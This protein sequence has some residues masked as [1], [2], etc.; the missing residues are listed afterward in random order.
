MKYQ[1]KKVLNKTIILLAVICSVASCAVEKKK[2]KEQEIAQQTQIEYQKFRAEW[3]AIGD[4]RHQYEA[5]VA[6]TPRQK[7]D[8]RIA[9]MEEVLSLDWTEQ[10]RQHIQS[11]IE[12]LKDEI[13]FLLIPPSPLPQKVVEWLNYAVEEFGWSRRCLDILLPVSFGQ[14]SLFQVMTEV[15]QKFLKQPKGVNLVS[16]NGFQ[17]ADD[18]ES[19]IND[20]PR[21]ISTNDGN[22]IKVEVINID[23][24]PVY[25]GLNAFITYRFDNGKIVNTIRFSGYVNATLREV[26]TEE[27]FSRLY[28]I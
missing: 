22:D 9:K 23:Y 21:T 1:I 26:L 2:C 8:M 15:D 24:L 20:Y 11:F 6:F 14:T 5:Y 17:I 27:E 12:F 10:E 13:D 19:L 7:Q 3:L 18:I 4:I 25:E 16:P 28:G